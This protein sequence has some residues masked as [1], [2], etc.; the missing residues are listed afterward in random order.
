VD[1]RIPREYSLLEARKALLDDV[2][3]LVTSCTTF[4]NVSDLP[5][6]HY[7]GFVFLVIHPHFSEHRYNTDGTR[8]T[9]LQR[10][11][12]EAGEST[13]MADDS[14]SVESEDDNSFPATKIAEVMEDVQLTGVPTSPEA[15]TLHQRLT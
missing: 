5:K 8:T 12:L 13:D 1:W 6:N 10:K 14:R 7:N 11:Q 4:P 2:K 15:S 3:D 9:K